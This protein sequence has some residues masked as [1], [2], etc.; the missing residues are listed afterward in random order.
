[1]E[2]HAAYPMKDIELTRGLDLKACREK[3][4]ENWNC[5]VFTW[6]STKLSKCIL[7]TSKRKLKEFKSKQRIGD[8][9]PSMNSVSGEKGPCK[10]CKIIIKN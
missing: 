4:E 10:G 5:Q 9:I 1:M 3:C 2:H 8:N 6:R 7:K